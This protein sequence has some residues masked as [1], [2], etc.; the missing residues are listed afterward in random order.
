MILSLFTLLQRT[1]LQRRKWVRF[2]YDRLLSC[3]KPEFVIIG[4]TKIFLDTTD[5]LRL[6][7]YGKWEE[8]ES[9]LFKKYIRKG[10]VI[11]DCGAHIGYYTI[12][13]ASKTGH[14]GRVYA[15]EPA[16]VNFDLLKRN[17]EVNKYHNVIPINKAVADKLGRA[18]IFSREK[19]TPSYQITFKEN[20]RFKIVATTS[21]DTFFVQKEKRVDVIKMDI[22]G[23]EMLA[24][25]GMRK[26][27]SQNE[28]V[29]LFAEFWPYGI[30]L[31]HRNAADFLHLLH[32][33]D[34][35]LYII[36]EK[37]KKL[38]HLIEKN[39]LKMYTVENKAHTNILC[40]KGYKNFEGS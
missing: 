29:A 23:A 39:I 16:M 13:A 40:L 32:F 12:L 31:L 15:F 35:K 34:F 22:E 10:D 17:I 8:F 37:K 1:G 38:I 3:L 30:K 36:D 24:L 19:T 26:I 7:I 18:Y 27:I 28:Q 33:L 2:F 20:K 11:I 6:S 5:S 14:S 25:E 4:K 9:D 21:L